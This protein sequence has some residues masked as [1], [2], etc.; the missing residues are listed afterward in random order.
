MGRKNPH[1]LA[2]FQAASERFTPF[3][4]LLDTL[5]AADA[6]GF[7]G[8]VGERRICSEKVGG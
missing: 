7:R 1:T 8:R 6:L 2:T 3:L 4:A 5:L